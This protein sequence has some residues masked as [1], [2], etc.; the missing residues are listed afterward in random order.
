M[1]DQSGKAAPESPANVTQV[2]SDDYYPTLPHETFLSVWGLRQVNIGTYL[3]V[4]N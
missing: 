4:I 2:G 1:Q 3:R